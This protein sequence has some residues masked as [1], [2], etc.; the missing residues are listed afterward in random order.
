[1]EFDMQS[2]APF[3]G[4]EKVMMTDLDTGQQEEETMEET[5]IIPA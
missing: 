1:M 2:I 3:A 5:K 4:S